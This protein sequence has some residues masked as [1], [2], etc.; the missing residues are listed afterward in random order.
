MNVIQDGSL[1]S[2][3]AHGRCENEA[4]TSP[5]QGVNS[6]LELE[7]VALTAPFCPVGGLPA[8]GELSEELISSNTR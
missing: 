4:G 1:R 2:S 6:E 3:T 8:D 7:V 5:R